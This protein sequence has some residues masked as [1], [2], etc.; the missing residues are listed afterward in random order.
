MSGYDWQ[1]EHD[2]D[3]ERAREWDRA[4]ERERAEELE[5]DRVTRDAGEDHRCAM[6]CRLVAGGTCLA[7][8]HSQCA[9]SMERA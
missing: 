8:G 5:R 6:G 1:P 7:P 9:L 4:D 3:R 2:D